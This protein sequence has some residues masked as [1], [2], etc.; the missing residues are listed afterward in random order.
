MRLKTQTRTA[1]ILFIAAVVFLFL[2]GETRLQAA[3]FE[4]IAVHAKAIS[5]AN[6]CVAY[7]PGH[8]AIHYNPAG[9][10][11]LR[12]GKQIS[13][14]LMTGKLEINA[15]MRAD[16][17]FDGW[18]DTFDNK[19]DPLNGL[20]SSVEGWH[21]YIPVLGEQDTETIGI[22]SPLGFFS[23]APLPL[24]ISYREPGS[25]WT[26]G[27]GAYAPS[28]GGYYRSD[29]DPGRYN[30]RAVSLQQITYA[31]P[32]VSYQLTDTVSIGLTVSMSQGAMEL[33]TDMRMPNDLMA[34]TKILGNTTE[35]LTIPIVTQLTLPAPWFGGG[36]GPYDDFANL[37]IK[38]RD[39]YCPGYNIGLLWEPKNWFAF[40][41]NYQSK[42]RME[43]QGVYK[44]TYD[45]KWQRMVSWFGS[46]PLL[47]PIAA[48]LELPYNSTPYE[49]GNVYLEG[50]DAPQRVQAGIMLRPFKRL[51]LMCDAHWIDYSQTKK[52]T[53]VFDQPVQPFKLAKLVGHT[54]GSNKLTMV[55]N[56]EDEI[57][58]SYG[59]ELQVLDWL[60]L[61]C[62]YEDRKTSINQQY[63][64]MFAPIPDL[65]FYGAGIGIKLKSGIE[66]DLSVG[67]LKSDKWYVPNNTS[68]N[69]N[70]TDFTDAVY[71][72]YGGLDFSGDMKISLLAANISMPFKHVYRFG[73]ILKE[74]LK[75]TKELIS[76]Q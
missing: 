45:E 15:N 11:N 48:M 23:A 63:F 9:L 35:G 67:L 44:F 22:D 74:S 10:S 3:F 34:L 56:M 70:S 64:D 58:M 68:E 53:F 42:V 39:D 65:D 38:A 7:P 37:S 50:F 61:R 21:L 1:P 41:A 20:S 40:G 24:G 72:P 69:L 26:F 71:N 36:I 14:G 59:A 29:N 60:F 8:M 16:P 17:E 55:R 30:G 51:R 32:S 73:N 12:A 25:R 18:L 13:L 47:V 27:F 6:S 52:W 76:F 49:A 62:G 31:A 75:K 46:T 28:I 57:H 43:Q 19:D 54:D 2:A 4:N 5:L 33:D 66:I